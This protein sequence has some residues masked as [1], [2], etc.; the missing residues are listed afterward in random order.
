MELAVLWHRA[1]S[2]VDESKFPFHDCYQAITTPIYRL[3]GDVMM[4][5]SARLKAIERIFVTISYDSL[6]HS[7]PMAQNE[8]W[9]FFWV[10]W[11]VAGVGYASTVIGFWSSLCYSIILAWNLYYL[12]ASFTSVLPWSS[13]GNSW[14]TELC[15]DFYRGNSNFTLL[16]NDTSMGLSERSLQ[17]ATASHE[18][19]EWVSLVLFCFVYFFWTAIP[20]IITGSRRYQRSLTREQTELD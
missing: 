11:R 10:T 19:W 17:K 6:P 20:C 14:N 8:L 5:G 15:R 13:C 1:G 16:V 12:F 18:Y 9:I 3:H 2:Y 7:S 4:H